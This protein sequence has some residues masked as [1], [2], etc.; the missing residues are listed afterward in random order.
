MRR[1]LLL[2]TLLVASLLPGAS[3]ALAAE[4]DPVLFVHGFSGNAGNWD[5]MAARFRSEG[6]RTAAFTYDS[7]QS[8]ATIALRVREEVERL[9]AATGA[10]KVDVV[11]HSM[12]A[13]SSRYYLRSLGGTAYVDDW[14]SIGGPNHGTTSAYACFVSA[15]RDMRF[16]SPFLT[17][18]N[19]GDETPGDV[20]YGTFRSRCDEVI[21]PDDSTVLAGATN[22]VTGCYGHLTLLAAY[23][24]YAGVRDFVR[25]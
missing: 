9:R 1:L 10:S 8:N 6:W 20:H 13:L 2:C 18:L 3:P 22:V 14:V 15:C 7:T 25:Y 16:G 12:G 21:N 5:L 17:A 19:T 23:D 11:T 24:V 4:R